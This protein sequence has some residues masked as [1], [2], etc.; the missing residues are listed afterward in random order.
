MPKPALS[1]GARPTR[2]A[3]RLPV[4]VASGEDICAGVGRRRRVSFGRARGRKRRTDVGDVGEREGLRGF[5]PDEVGESGKRVAVDARDEER[6]RRRG[7]WQGGWTGGRG[8]WSALILRTFRIIHIV[9]ESRRGREDGLELL[10]R[11]VD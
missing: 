11:L 2:G 8:R 9:R 3:M 7:T 10:G 5:S 1:T 6:R 4:K